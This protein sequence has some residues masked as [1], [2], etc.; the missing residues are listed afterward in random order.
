MSEV[1]GP[2]VD[3]AVSPAAVLDAMAR[4]VVVTDPAGLVMQ[5]NQAAERLYGWTATEAVGRDV[6][7]LLLP[8]AVSADASE[9]LEHLRAGQTWSGDFLVRRKDG[10]ELRVAVTDCGIVDAE[11]ALVGLVGESVDITARRPDASAPAP[12]AGPSPAADLATSRLKGLQAVTAALSRAVDTTQVATVIL[13]QGVAELGGHTGSLCLL[14]PDGT[15]VEIVHEV[16]YRREVTERWSR[17]PLDGPLPASEVI[18]TG[19]P[20]VLRSRADRDERYPIFVGT[21]LVGDQAYAIAPLAD[22]DGRP[23]GAMVIGFS[24]PRD[25]TADDLLLLEALAGQGATALRRSQLYEAEQA[26]R[27]RAE[28][29]QLRLAYLAE[30]SATLAASLDYEQTLHRVAA[31]AVP[32]LADWCG[33]H[34]V[35]G[36]GAVRSLALAHVDSDKVEYLEQLFARFPVDPAAAAGPGAVIRTGRAEVYP[37]VTDEMLVTLARSADHLELLRQIGVGSGVSIPL[38]AR[39][40]VCGAL[41]LGN[42]QGRPL[43]PDDVSLA[44][45]LAVRA[46]VAIDNALLFAER[47]HTARSL[48]ASLLPP[49]L[50]TIPDL[51]LGSGYLA[52]GEGTEVGGDFYDVVRTGSGWLLVVGD[53]RG[54]GIEAA[55]V[56]GLARH[57]IRSAAMSGAGPSEILAHLNRVLLQAEDDRAVTAA[58]PG[59]GRWDWSEPRFCTAA[60]VAVEP[61]GDGFTATVC[62]A[63]H[64]FPLVGR[65]G[66][67]VEPVGRAG[68]LLGVLSDPDLHEST[69]ALGPGDVLVC[70]TDGI[71]ERHQAGRFFEEAGIAAVLAQPGAAGAQVLATRIEGAARAFVSEEPHD[72]MAVLVLRVPPAGGG[73]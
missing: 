14:A 61:E 16:G 70:F 20:V 1:A 34:L 9:I 25:F 53:V 31:L 72:D 45:E 38:R 12:A 64:P 68:T 39:D 65:A 50:P 66:G 51:E 27:R 63:G 24:Q 62:S 47:S 56:T 43:E 46:G 71:V 52:A 32:R 23:F 21:P 67:G 58:P 49:S 3:R 28:Q 73:D 17:F 36:R 4:A 22:E 59:E 8:E 29:A 41:S 35:D 33:V 30:A 60:L 6:V 42:E 69:V 19:R 54:K 57:T 5:W 11:G 18:R 48:Q 26:A 40:Q 7:E 44:E 13:N 2:T 37:E 55:A 15:T 10:Q